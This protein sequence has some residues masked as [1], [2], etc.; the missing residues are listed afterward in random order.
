MKGKWIQFEG[1]RCKHPIGQFSV[2]T[3]G[4]ELA[5]DRGSRRGIN[6]HLKRSH[7]SARFG[8]L[9]SLTTR[10]RNLLNDTDNKSEV[11]G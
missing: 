1:T 4:L 6:L 8:A 10:L 5:Y 7:P 3:V 2:F 11:D 9:S